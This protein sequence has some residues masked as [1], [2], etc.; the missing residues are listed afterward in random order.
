MKSTTSDRDNWPTVNIGRTQLF[1][2]AVQKIWELF[3]LR[4]NEDGGHSKALPECPSCYGV[5]ARG[6]DCSEII[7]W[8]DTTLRATATSDGSRGI[9]R[10]KNRRRWSRAGQRKR[11]RSGGCT[12]SSEL[13]ASS[14]AATYHF[15]RDVRGRID[16]SKSTVTVK[17]IRTDGDN[18]GQYN[19]CFQTETLRKCIRSDGLHRTISS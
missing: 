10:G 15:Y 19:H 2:I 11:W 18:Y 6:N 1:N 7:T 9:E 8:N 17:R 16:S 13:R 4:R 3:L 14:V 12:G 5:F